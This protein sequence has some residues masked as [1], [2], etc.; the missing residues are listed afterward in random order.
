LNPPDVHGYAHVHIEGPVPGSGTLPL[1]KSVLA[2]GN[3]V[4]VMANPQ[5]DYHPVVYKCLRIL[6]NTQILESE[7]SDETARSFFINLV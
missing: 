5:R 7:K 3:L 2:G 4:S 1:A 6:A